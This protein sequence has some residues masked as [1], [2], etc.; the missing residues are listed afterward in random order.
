MLTAEG[1]SARRDRL[2][3]ALPASCDLLILAAPE[4]LVYFANFYPSP[5]VFRTV[6]SGALLVLEPGRATLV[7]DNLLEPFL[8]RAHVDENVAPVWYSGQRSTVHRRSLLVDS[9]L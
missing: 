2:W 6:E 1:C 8:D 9:V 5:F 7:A 3:E 4:H